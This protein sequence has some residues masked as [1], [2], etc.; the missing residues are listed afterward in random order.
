ME[1]GEKWSVAE[2]LLACKAFVPASE[3]AKNGVS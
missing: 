1:S 3:D 2:I